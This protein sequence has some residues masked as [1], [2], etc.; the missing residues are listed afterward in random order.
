MSAIHTYYIYLV[1]KE[2]EK[3]LFTSKISSL[4]FK[5]YKTN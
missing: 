4:R 2:N 3:I 1:L 5:D